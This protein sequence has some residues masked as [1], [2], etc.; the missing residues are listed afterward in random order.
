MNR[1]D[2]ENFGLDIF[3]EDG[4]LGMDYFLKKE[5]YRLIQRTYHP[6]MDDFSYGI[7]HHGV[8]YEDQPDQSNS[9]KDMVSDDKIICLYCL[10]D[11]AT[12]WYAFFSHT[13]NSHPALRGAF[14]EDEDEVGHCCRHPQRSNITA[15]CLHSIHIFA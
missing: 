3:V 9:S 13:L 2:Y 14:R 12:G 5:G 15:S 6:Q 8:S 7:G 10:R 4:I 11:I 1:S